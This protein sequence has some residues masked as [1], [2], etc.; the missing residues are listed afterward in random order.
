MAV[1]NF[2]CR[3]DWIIYNDPGGGGNKQNFSLSIFICRLPGQTGVFPVILQIKNRQMAVINFVCRDDWIINNDPGGGGNKQNFSLSI[4]ICRLPGQTGVFPVILQI[5]NRRMAVINFVCRDDWIIYNDPGGG[6]N[7]QNF[8]LS[9]FICRL[10]GQT[11]VFPV[12]LQIKNRQMAV[13]NFVCR[14]DWIINNDPGG[15]GNKQNFSLSIFI[16]RLPG[17]TGVFPVILQ[18]KN[19]RMAVINFVCRDDWIIYN[20]PGGGGNKQ[21]F[22]LS[23]FICRL[24]GQ[25]GVFPVILQIK[26]R[27]MA[28]IN[29]VCRDDWIRTSGLFVPNEA[30]YRAALHPEWAANLVIL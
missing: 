20:D 1:I 2:V 7:K 4:F 10:P 23:I 19:R 11:G 6:G 13:I 29:F 25:T 3:D 17:Q 18:I 12:I 21:N 22:S 5:K 28:V 8:S 26:N 16:C 30:R 15:G 24:P 27:R 9:I 14:D